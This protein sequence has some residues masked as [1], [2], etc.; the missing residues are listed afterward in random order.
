MFSRILGVFVI[1]TGFMFGVISRL[2]PSIS[3]SR[4]P[5]TV[6]RPQN[7]IRAHLAVESRSWRAVSCSSTSAVGH[8]S[9]RLTQR[10]DS[11]FSGNRLLPTS[12][13]FASFSSNYKTL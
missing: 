10:V 13:A 11:P 12:S 7:S 5:V 1:T 9:N 6:R 8:A 2:M 3:L 4:L